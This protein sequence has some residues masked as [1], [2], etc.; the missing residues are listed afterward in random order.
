VTTL[1]RH[2]SRPFVKEPVPETVQVAPH[3]FY[4]SK[5]LVKGWFP[6]R[7]KPPPLMAYI[8]KIVIFPWISS[9]RYP[10]KSLESW[11]LFVMMKLLTFERR[12]RQYGV[13]GKGLQQSNWDG[14][15][16]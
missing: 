4:L 12:N 11:I 7:D 10:K 15:I 8:I 3:F 14:G 1:A 13:Y 2:L 16:Q 5:W 6:V 9:S